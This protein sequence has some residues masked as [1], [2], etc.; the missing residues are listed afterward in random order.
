M[1]VQDM[2][3]SYVQFA[4]DLVDLEDWLQRTPRRWTG[5]SSF[6]NRP[7]TKWDLGV[8]Y[9]GALK[10]AKQGWTKGAADLHFAVQA[11]PQQS[12]ATTIRYDV[13]GEFPDIARFTAGDPL[14]MRS[15]RRQKQH[16]PLIHMVV[17]VIASSGT[18]ASAFA[19]YGAA[20]VALIDQIENTG[21]RVELDVVT[22][23]GTT[24]TRLVSGWKVKRAEDAC[25][26]SAIAFSVAHPAAYRR[27][28]FAMWE[29]S[30]ADMYR[31]GY[32]S[33]ETLKQS[34]AEAIGAADALLIDGIGTYTE[35]KPEK[36]LALAVR[37]INKAAGETL[38]E[39]E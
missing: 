16:S 23:N 17:N 10:M 31:P 19:N 9:T 12:R 5:N 26:L 32:G 28:M 2:G 35:L 22:V 27:L 7:Q 20:L 39:V 37:Q 29:R 33:C 34:D 30:R 18:R 36:A 24:G 38:V 13:A 21:R 6:T 1:I 4:N 25:D 15:H 3:R 8:G 11:L 14:H